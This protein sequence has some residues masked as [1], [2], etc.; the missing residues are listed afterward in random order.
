MNAAEPLVPFERVGKMVGQLTHDVRNRLSGMQLQSAYV[1]DLLTDPKDAAEA[2][3]EL[4][5]LRGMIE[6]YAKSL[7]GFS[8]RFRVPP[9]ELV[10]YPA[11][12]L[13]E[14]FCQRLA[15]VQPEFA[16]QVTW[17]VELADE[18]VEVDPEMTF[19]ALGEFFQNAAHFQEAG[20]PVLA[21]ASVE[22]GRF[23]LALREH[24][25]ALPS[26]PAAWGAEPLVSTRDGG[27]GLGIFH[28]RQLLAA[29]GGGVDFT[30]DPVAAQL[31]TRIFLPLAP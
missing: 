28:A 25:T 5:R 17:T 20:A 24:K 6:D 22:G 8:R 29:H 1:A 2:A 15:R 27:Y 10:R 14:D 7:K 16:P 9:P 30:H 3:R 11:K 18:A 23:C 21:R 13:I 4:K 31:T 19:E 12:S 26:D